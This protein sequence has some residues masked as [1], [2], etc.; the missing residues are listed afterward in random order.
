[1]ALTDAVQL[2]QT[3]SSG[4]VGSVSASVG[5]GLCLFSQIV[6]SVFVKLWNV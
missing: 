1:M 4:I 6:E 3:S 5:I 2:Q